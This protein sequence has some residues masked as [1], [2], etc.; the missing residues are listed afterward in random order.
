MGSLKQ[1]RSIRAEHLSARTKCIQIAIASRCQLECKILCYCVNHAVFIKGSRNKLI[2]CQS[3]ATA[4]GFG[5]LPCAHSSHSCRTLPASGKFPV[6]TDGIDGKQTRKH[7]GAVKQLVLTTQTASGSGSH[8]K[9]S[10]S[11]RSK[12]STAVFTAGQRLNKII[13]YHVLIYSELRK[14]SYIVLLQIQN[15]VD[16]YVIW[17]RGSTVSNPM[18]ARVRRRRRRRCRRP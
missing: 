4:N 1:L 15:E 8:S 3:F 9:H 6:T 16:S 12:M 10:S 18:L 7:A 14:K 17:R 11:V 2:A 5:C 13:K